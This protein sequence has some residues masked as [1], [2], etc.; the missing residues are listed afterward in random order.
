MLLSSSSADYDVIIFTETWL[1]NDIRNAEF[2]DKRY[3]IYRKDRSESSI[4]RTASRGGGVFISV[5][6]DILSEEYVN[7]EMAD[8]EAICIRIPLSSGYLYIYCLYIQPTAS[9]ETYR[10]HIVAIKKL[11]SDMSK[12]DMLSLMGDFNLGNSVDWNENDCGFDYIPIIGDSISQKAIIARH[13]TSE[14]LELGLFQISKH[15]NSSGNVLDLVYTN[16]PEL[17]VT[18]DPDFLMLPSFK[19]DES[20]VPLMCT[21]DC[22]PGFNNN[23]VS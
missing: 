12:N 14:M 20:H 11:V 6:S 16:V 10:S 7:D 5:K 2:F 18:A 3:T 9:L 19:S 13:V 21:I 22:D 4:A 23:N 8:L 15:C 17:S 1:K